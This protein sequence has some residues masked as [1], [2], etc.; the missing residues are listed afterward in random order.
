MLAPDAWRDEFIAT[1]D[2]I[3]GV[4]NKVAGLAGPHA[5]SQLRWPDVHKLSEGLYLSGWTHW[6][7]FLRELMVIDVANDR[8]GALRDA[9]AFRT[10]GGPERL[11]RFLLD[12]PDEKRWIEWSNQAEAITRANQFLATGHRY[13]V[14][15]AHQAD[16]EMMRRIRNAVAHKSDRAWESFKSLARAAPFGLAPNQMRGITPGRFLSAHRWGTDLVIVAAIGKLEAAARALV[17]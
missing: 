6:E 9:K 13:S 14:L 11:A 5:T 1:L 15:T 7:Q 17:P 4:F 3:R 10:K 16:F 2:H 12:H 8:H